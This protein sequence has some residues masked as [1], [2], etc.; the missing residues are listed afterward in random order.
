MTDAVFNVRSPIDK[1]IRLTATIWR[2]IQRSHPEFAANPEYLDDLR[3]TLADPDY[4]VKGW[5]NELLALRWCERAP[6]RPKHL[7][8]VYR[9]L[10]GEGFVITAFFISRHEKV[11]RREIVWQR[12]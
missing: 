1:D 6:A 11:L 8:V 7:C 5:T 3:T 4:V 9:E 10:N 2:K 12:S